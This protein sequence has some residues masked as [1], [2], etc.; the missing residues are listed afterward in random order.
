MTVGRAGS[1]SLM[2]CLE[3][4]DDI[5][6]PNKNTTCT[7]NEL[8]YPRDIRQFAKAYSDLRKGPVRNADE[9]IDAFFE[10]NA[11]SAFAGFKTMPNRHKDYRGF[12]TRKDIQFITLDRRDVSSTA[13]SFF[14][15]E[16]METYR[17]RGEEHT[18]KFRFERDKHARRVAGNLAYLHQGHRRLLRIPNAIRLDYEDLCDPAY[19]SQ[20][21]EEFFG[22]PIRL[23]NPRPPT[24]G[25]VYIENWDEFSKFV[26][27][28]WPRLETQWRRKL[29]ERKAQSGGKAEAGG[30]AQAAGP[31][32]T[33]GQ[34]AAAPKPQAAGKA[35]G[36][37]KAR[38]ARK[39]KPGK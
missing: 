11:Q 13:A 9:L 30:S 20:P 25:N 18:E 1:T 33:A 15:A 32:Q 36:P 7:N 23:Q 16:F 34:A 4:F 19:V 8:L 3:R 22:R 5:A 24:Q 17:R 14:V 39:P 31:K 6:V 21:L 29:A 38:A 37:R 27:T 10:V 12:V 35:K 2:E 26:E 28:V